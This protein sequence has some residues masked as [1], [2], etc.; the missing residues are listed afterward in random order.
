MS[1]RLPAIKARDLVRILGQ[2]GFTLVRQKGSHAFFHHSDGRNTS[3]PIH[4]GDIPRPVLHE[5]LK[6]IDVSEEEIRK[7][8]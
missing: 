7:Y 4:S 5:I 1:G 3:V 8:L 2:L 6:Q